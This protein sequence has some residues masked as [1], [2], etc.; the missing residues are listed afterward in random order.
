[1]SR[2]SRTTLIFTVAVLVVGLCIVLSWRKVLWNGPSPAMNRVRV[3][4]ICRELEETISHITE[5]F[6]RNDMKSVVAVYNQS[7]PAREPV[8]T[9][10]DM[11][12]RELI[13]ICADAQVVGIASA[14]ANG[15]WRDWDDVVFLFQVDLDRISSRQSSPTFEFVIPWAISK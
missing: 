4:R 1:M 3:F 2:I 6:P 11:Y 12:D 9:L 5:Q 8:T 13:L 7:S 10:T 15:L 14:G